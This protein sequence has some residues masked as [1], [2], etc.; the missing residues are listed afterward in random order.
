M[1]D[2]L[3]S[4][5]MASSTTSAELF[6]PYVGSVAVYGS[7]A[8][9]PSSSTATAT[10]TATARTSSSTVNKQP[11]VRCGEVLGDALFVGFSDGTL[12]RYVPFASASGSSGGGGSS[13]SSSSSSSNSNS[14][15]QAQ[16]TETHS[17][18]LSSS[19]KPVEKILPVNLAGASLL[20]V[21]VESNLHFLRCTDLSSAPSFHRIS[22]VVTFAPDEAQLELISGSSDSATEPAQGNGG[23]VRIALIK[24]KSVLPLLL[25]SRG[26]RQLKELALPPGGAVLAKR[27]Q[28]KLLL[29]NTST[30]VLMDMSITPASSGNGQ[31]NGN[32][33]IAQLGLPISQASDRPSPKERPS[34]VVV[35]TTDRNGQTACEFLLTSYAPTGTLGVFVGSDGE[36]R[37]KLLEWASHPR[38][39]SLSGDATLYS[40]LRDDHLEIH[41]LAAGATSGE[42]IRRVWRGC[43]TR[44]SAEDAQ[45]RR[46]AAP[47]ELD[48][49]RGLSGVFVGQQLGLHLRGMH[50]EEHLLDSKGVQEE[51]QGMG[52]PHVLLLYKDGLEHVTRPTL[53]QV[54]NDLI[55]RESWKKLEELIQ[56]C[57]SVSGPPQVR[58][59]GTL[60]RASRE[61]AAHFL[62]NVEFARAETY[63]DLSGVDPLELVGMLDHTDFVSLVP[64]PQT[65]PATSLI[66]NDAK[67]QARSSLRALIRSNLQTNYC[68][69]ILEEELSSAQPFA[70]LA[71]LL[72]R[73]FEELLVR[74][75]Q[76]QRQR[77]VIT[78][79]GATRST[80][81]SLAT[82]RDTILGQLLLRRLSLFP[83]SS[84]PSD[85]ALEQALRSFLALVHSDESS[86]DWQVLEETLQGLGMWSAL[87]VIWNR[88]Q[89]QDARQEREK[90]KRIIQLR[91]ELLEGVKADRFAPNAIDATGSLA[92]DGTHADADAPVRT[93]GPPPVEEQVRE[94]VRLLHED[95][96]QDDEQ[97]D[98]EQADGEQESEWKRDIGVRLI[99]WDSDAG[100]KLLTSADRRGRASGL[101]E[102]DTVDLT[103]KREGDDE[104]TLKELRE[105]HPDAV[106]A[107]LEHAVLREEAGESLHLRSEIV[108]VLLRS[109]VPDERAKMDMEDVAHEY[110]SG[111]YAESFAAHLVLRA[112]KSSI[113]AGGGAPF[114]ET[115]AGKR[116]QSVNAYEARIKLIL[117]LQTFE[118]DDARAVLNKLQ[119][120]HWAA[121]ER[122]ILL[123]KVL[124]HAH[125]LRILALE[126]RDVHSAEAYCAQAGKVISPSLAEFL[127]SEVPGAD[128]YVGKVEQTKKSKKKAALHAKTRARLFE[129]LLDIYI[130]GHESARGVDKDLLI[131][132]SHLLNTQSRY[133]P[134]PKVLALLPS[135]YPLSSLETFIASKLRSQLHS[136]HQAR[137]V[138]AVSLAQNLEISEM[139]WGKMRSAGGVLVEDENDLGGTCGLEEEEQGVVEEEHDL[140]EKIRAEQPASAEKHGFSSPGRVDV[141][142]SPPN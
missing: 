19:N 108:D 36:V 89:S 38:A 8:F 18:D 11:V 7:A 5:L 134:L 2:D 65:D 16:L 15:T 58:S 27:W 94:I 75:L 110:I 79:N 20:L 120:Q 78:Q 71:Q 80:S 106:L 29:A 130:A 14:S 116:D 113:P 95:V 35:P 81:A 87:L 125:A 82:A 127:R 60:L 30:Y 122:A 3:H 128:M 112:K 109:I 74:L 24:R 10:A 136:T 76:A 121:F 59:N 91:L 28:D 85:P 115:D 62:I 57:S 141:L 69:P 83:L 41:Q 40:L 48:E 61:L 68:P 45:R 126:L 56:H 23:L 133:F 111:N 72:E 44:R 139:A 77:Q 107:F 26:Y 42:E 32:S 118:M 101:A 43:V 98:G 135:A 124:E 96:A 131:P 1:G 93:P 34:I 67:L 99:R 100:I 90:K 92:R 140:T 51:Q 52:V 129:S 4:A 66:Q 53:S 47:E 17:V 114:I 21:L 103:S 46:R 105:H 22:G 9:P 33:N 142:A 73:R 84:S 49:P 64:S 117:L 12:R 86:C 31:E 119:G 123:G 63:L 55:R 37:P 104:R 13:S 54:V 88:R 132:T 6:E 50:G 39:L 70:H 137:I 138:R 102:A 25:S 97:A